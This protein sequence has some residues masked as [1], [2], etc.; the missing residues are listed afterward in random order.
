MLSNLPPGVTGNEDIFGPDAEVPMSVVCGRSADLTVFTAEFDDA[1]GALLTRYRAIIKH[2]R[3]ETD[4]P[5][6][7]ARLLM[8]IG[9][10]AKVVPD[11]PTVEAICPFEA[12]EWDV[13]VYGRGPSA[14]LEW[15]CPV[16]GTEHTEM[17]EDR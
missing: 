13:A 6:A 11:L 3:G 14:R 7:L 10:A 17:G 16:C 8:A 2:G 15:T 12:D 4:D 5:G 1:W 9:E